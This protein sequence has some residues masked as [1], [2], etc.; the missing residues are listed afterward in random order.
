MARRP[1]KTAAQET[2]AERPFR[3]P[4]ETMELF[5][6]NA[7]MRDLVADWDAGRLH[8]G[9]L[10]TGPHGIGK[11]TLA[12]ALARR[13]LTGET[14]T[15]AD[16]LQ[17]PAVRQIIAGAHPDLLVLD[18][19]ESTGATRTINV[20]TIRSLISFF[21]M[22]ASGSSGGGYRV[23][24]IDRADD[25]N[26]ASANA[27]L[28]LLEEPPRRAVL[29]L[30]CETPGRLPATVRSRCRKVPLR[31]LEPDALDSA[32]QA[33]GGEGTPAN[34]GLQAWIAGSVARALMAQDKSL[35]RVVTRTRKL[36]A[37]LPNADAK[38]ISDYAATFGP[39]EARPM[40]DI[41]FEVLDMEL[42]ALAR[43]RAVNSA[44]EGE[45]IAACASRITDM[46]READVLNL[47]RARS[48]ITAFRELGL[49]LQPPR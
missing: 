28:K 15:E 12:Y 47:D 29:M 45:R 13:L 38:D 30:L 39:R 32:V 49:A 31:G 2:A 18:G 33:A 11:A 27:L 42:A 4:R 6:H 5:G 10:I 46:K 7:A 44:G 40:F 8:H 41:A 22:T 25:L 34:D 23:G 37:A 1:A 36:V 3:H 35:A 19:D 21:N 43:T 17:L 48:V 16:N 9:L 14:G 26:T 20:E 24:I